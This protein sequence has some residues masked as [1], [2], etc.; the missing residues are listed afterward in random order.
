MSLVS[1]SYVVGVRLDTQ[2]VYMKFVEEHQPIRG[3]GAGSPSNR[4]FGR[5]FGL[6]KY[7]SCDL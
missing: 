7:T 1:S 3:G 2:S 5:G 6:A 4:R